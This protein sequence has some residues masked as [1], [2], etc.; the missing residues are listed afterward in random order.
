M[1]LRTYLARNAGTILGTLRR[2]IVKDHSHL[3]LLILSRAMCKLDTAAL[4]LGTLNPAK[5]KTPGELQHRADID[6]LHS[7]IYCASTLDCTELYN[8][9]LQQLK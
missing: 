6:C 2:A 4:H 7:L 5:V 9:L 8:E 1:K 3:P